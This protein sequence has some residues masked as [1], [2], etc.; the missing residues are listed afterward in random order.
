MVVAVLAWCTIL[1]RVR[2]SARSRGSS[3]FVARGEATRV[4]ELQRAPADSDAKRVTAVA[5]AAWTTFAARTAVPT[6]AAA[7]DIVIC[8]GPR[9]AT[10][11]PLSTGLTFS[12]GA[13]VSSVASKESYSVEDDLSIDSNHRDA[14]ASGMSPEAALAPAA[15]A[16]T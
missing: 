4:F 12:S 3:T 14:R 1:R 11:A 6:R 5:T 16:A 2:V 8:A 10:F 9:F 13:A 15:P 7:P